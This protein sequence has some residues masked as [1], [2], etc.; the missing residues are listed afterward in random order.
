[1]FYHENTQH[2]RNQGSRSVERQ[3]F[4]QPRIY[5]RYRFVMLFLIF[6]LFFFLTVLKYFG[7]PYIKLPLPLN[8]QP[9]PY[10]NLFFSP[11]DLAPQPLSLTTLSEFFFYSLSVSGKRDL[12]TLT[13]SP[14][15][16]WVKRVNPSRYSNAP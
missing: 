7:A 16:A 11:S 9:T 3:W 8:T 6:I 14:R 12:W 4:A 15:S 2:T 13:S 5:R 10:N 1:M